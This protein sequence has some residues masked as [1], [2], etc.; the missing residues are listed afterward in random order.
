VV[1]V[2]ARALVAPRRRA[3][4][5][6]ADGTGAADGAIGGAAG[7]STPGWP[8]G[9]LEEWLTRPIPRVPDGPDPLDPLDPPVDPNHLGGPRDPARPADPADL[10]PPTEQLAAVPPLDLP[11]DA[12]VPADAPL[13]PPTVSA[14]PRAAAPRATRRRGAASRRRRTIT[15]AVVLAVLATL[16]TGGATAVAADK[17]VTVTVDGRDRIVHTFA[18]DVGGA[19][20]SAGIVATAQDRLEPAPATELADGDH[21]ILRRARPLTL[22]EGPSERRLWTTAASLGDALRSAGVEAQPIQMSTAPTTAIPLGGMAVELRVPRT[23]TI[24]DGNHA[25]EKVATLVGTVGALL[26][27]R[28][29]TLGVDDVSVP[30]GDTPLTDGMDVQ[31]VRNGVGEVVEV[32]KIPPP[33]EVVDDPDLP[34]GKREIVDKGRAGEQAV[35]LRVFV[36]N[37]E[38][39]RRE[40]VRAGATTPP[41]KR[42]VKVGTNDDAPQKASAPPAGPGSWDALARCEAGGNWATNSGNGYYGGLQFDRQ[43]WVAYGGDDYAPLP[44][45]AGRDAQIAIASKVRDDRGGYSSWPA[46][47][48]KL[49]LPT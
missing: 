14:A 37:G 16:V 7:S 21:V 20:A 40:Q 25:P 12:A 11:P 23:V 6:W 48:H 39:V 1:D 2:S 41:E 27:E 36:S 35:V 28:G 9:D 38:E 13:D 33:E 42:V 8:G 4:S 43:T 34:R 49:G 19:L 29:V 22:V 45:Q 10:D 47:A 5:S 44:H 32:H 46:C 31:V 17:V 30:A 24:T 26:A 15:Q 18:G 3:G